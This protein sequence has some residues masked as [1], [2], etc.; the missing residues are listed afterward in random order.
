MNLLKNEK[1]YNIG[2][3][4]EDGSESKLTKIYEMFKMEKGSKKL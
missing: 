2:G 1:A 4:W 3:S